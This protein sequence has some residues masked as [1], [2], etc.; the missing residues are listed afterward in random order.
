M[1]MVLIPNVSRTRFL[2]LAALPWL[3][4]VFGIAGW[5]WSAALLLAAS[6]TALLGASGWP[7]RILHARPAF[8]PL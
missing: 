2:I 7:L 1:G 4:F 6:F 3:A 8:V 5:H